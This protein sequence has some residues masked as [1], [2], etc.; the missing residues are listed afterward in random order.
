MEAWVG[1]RR[2]IRSLMTT[3]KLIWEQFVQS[4]QWRRKGRKMVLLLKAT[5]CRFL[6]MKL[7][8]MYIRIN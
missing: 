1:V 8:G 2:L 3:Y 4:A 7:V 6:L 5:S